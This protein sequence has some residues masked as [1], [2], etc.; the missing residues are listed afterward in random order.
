MESARLAGFALGAALAAFSGTHVTLAL[1][2]AVVRPRW[3]GAAAFLVPPL[4]PWWGW[5]SGMRRRT[6][7]WAVALAL[8]AS[9][10][11]AALLVRPTGS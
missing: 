10:V 5:R 1:S 6:L 11:G 8:Y 9:G 2:L 7:A 4:A 3:R